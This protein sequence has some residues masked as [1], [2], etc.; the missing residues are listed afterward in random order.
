LILPTTLPPS[1]FVVT[2]NI[3]EATDR[4]HPSISRH[5]ARTYPTTMS[6]SSSTTPSLT[7]PH[8]IL[9]PI[10]LEP[11]NTSLQLL[12]QE[13]YAN[14]K[15]VHSTRGGGANGH[16]ALVMPPAEYLARTAQAFIAPVHPGDQ[17]ILP[18]NPTAHQITETNRQYAADLAEHTRYLT[19]LETLKQQLLTA[20]SPRYVRILAHQTFGFADVSC[21]DLLAHLHTTYG[22]ITNDDLE[23]NRNKLYA[24]WNPDDP[25]EDLWLRIQEI[26]RYATD[27]LEPITDAT[28]MRI[29]LEILE[30]TGVFP[31]GCSDWR[32]LATP[33]S[34][35]TSFKDHFTKANKERKRQGTAKTTGFH[36]A[37][38]AATAPSVPLPPTVAVTDASAVTTG[39]CTLYYCWTHGLGKNRAHTSQTCKNKATGHQDAATASNL[40]GGNT[41]I[42]APPS[43]PRRPAGN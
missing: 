21:L 23:L 38:A 40:M 27:G 17:P 33:T 28:V 37:H 11:N 25:M 19:V 3:F 24:A 35:Y 43:R 9:S 22:V 32:K 42:M 18:P 34:T 5:S 2:A 14:A 29:T 15:S 31:E 10:L 7:F 41:T 6:S 30:K 1:P 26:Q 8:P 20:V 13:L 36:G 12:Q 39:N 16:L 4:F